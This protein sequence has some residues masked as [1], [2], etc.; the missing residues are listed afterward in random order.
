MSWI[1]SPSGANIALI[2]PCDVCFNCKLC[3]VKCSGKCD[4]E[5]ECK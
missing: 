2:K 1:V 3:F 5:N 4:P